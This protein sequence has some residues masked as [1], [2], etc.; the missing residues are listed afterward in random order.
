MNEKYSKYIDSKHGFVVD[1]SVS[2]PINKESVLDIIFL[3]E[4]LNNE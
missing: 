3:L 1:Y 4:L 2:Q